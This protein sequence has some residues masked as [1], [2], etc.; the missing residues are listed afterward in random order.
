MVRTTRYNPIVFVQHPFL[1]MLIFTTVAS[2]DDIRQILAL[3]QKN[4]ARN[5][6]PEQLNSQG[7]VT[8]EHD[9]DI[10][11]RMNDAEPSTI[12]KDE[13]RV[14]AYC[15][16]MTRAFGYSIPILA[17]MFD[18]FKK[19]FFDGQTLDAFQ[20]IVMGQ[21]CIDEAYRGIGL[22]DQMY[23][24]Y[25]E[26][27][28]PRYEIAITEISPRNQRSMRAHARVGFETALE[29]QAPDGQEWALVVW[30]WR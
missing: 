22:F 10:L 3:Q 4:L 21:V 24:A 13:G 11:K 18:S 27:L 28:S 14:I 20:Y 25:R 16:A 7:F 5:I 6:T 19:T 17:P 15:L 30:D 1:F 8:V 12:V 26:N 2:D 23:A 29:Y 9:F